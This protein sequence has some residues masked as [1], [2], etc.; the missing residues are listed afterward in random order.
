MLKQILSEYVNSSSYRHPNN[1]VSL[2]IFTG[3]GSIPD[4][5]LSALKT[6]R[7]LGIHSE[8]VSDGIIDLIDCGAVTNAR[9][10]IQTGKVVTGFAIGTERLYKFLDDNPFIG[11]FGLFEMININFFHY[12]VTCLML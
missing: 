1:L 9:K 7:D 12:T 4:A 3:I 8:M 10:V 2:T 11:K 6:H 5:V